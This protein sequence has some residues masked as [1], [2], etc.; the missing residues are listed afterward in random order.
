MRVSRGL[1]ELLVSC[2][3]EHDWSAPVARAVDLARELPPERIVAAATYHRVVGCVFTSLRGSPL[4]A[5]ELL[6]SL[7]A[8]VRRASG[9]SMLAVAALS[10]VRAALGEDVTWLAVKGPILD[11]VLYPRS[12]LRSYR[13]LDVLVAPWQLRDAVERLEDAGYVVADRN[14]R[15]ILRTV[16]GEL[17]L[18]REGCAPVDLHWTL[19]FDADVRERFRFETGAMIARSRTVQVAGGPVRTLDRVDTLLHLAVH[20]ALEGGDRLVWLKD[21][22]VA[23]RDDVPWD[24]LVERARA[25]GVQ[26]P[27]A[28]LLARAAHVLGSPVPDST[29]AD[30]APKTWRALTGVS[31]AIFPVAASRGIGTPSTLL[32]RSARKNVRTTLL[33]AARGLGRRARSVGGGQ[34]RRVDHRA[35]P[36]HVSSLRHPSGGS[37]DREEYLARVATLGGASGR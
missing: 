26:L 23:A 14:W 35:D 16:A 20:A 11:A 19:V 12:R 4:V 1:S 28:M 6:S 31:D 13:D 8:A 10:S 15:L 30:L 21:L 3:R 5:P 37:A 29:V 32:A 18:Q 25:Y 22:D 9:Q 2:T 27:T 24:E 7:A 17:H 36:A 33:H 34:L